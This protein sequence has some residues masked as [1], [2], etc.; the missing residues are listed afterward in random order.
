MDDRSP[1]GEEYVVSS[2][3]PGTTNIL[4]KCIIWVEKE[5][6]NALHFQI[7]RGYQIMN[8]CPIRRQNQTF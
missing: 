6:E 5:L 1:E 2:S 3:K 7:S 4:R 8:V